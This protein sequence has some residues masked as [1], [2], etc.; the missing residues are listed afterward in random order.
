MSHADCWS[1]RMVFTFGKSCSRG[2]PWVGR[3]LA[4][5]SGTLEY[6]DVRYHLPG[7]LV[8]VIHWTRSLSWFLG[9]LGRASIDLSKATKLADAVFRSGSL[10]IDWI[11]ATL[12][13]ITPKHRELRQIS[14]YAFC[15]STSVAFGAGVE[16]TIGDEIFGQWS[17]LDR[18]LVQLWES[19][20]IRPKFVC[21]ILG[22]VP[23][24]AEE[25]IG[26]LLPKTT[27]RGVINLIK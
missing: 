8:L 24:D 16:R 15:R 3:L 11:T 12:E 14:I 25:Y 20:S 10:N 1:Y 5:C 21:E 4:A 19:R 27:K 9:Y 17:D 7:P 13:T 6:L 23:Q 22:L 2:A 26:R 18:L